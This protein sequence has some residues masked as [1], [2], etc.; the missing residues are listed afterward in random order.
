LQPLNARSAS[1]SISGLG[2]ILC[3]CASLMPGK[4]KPAQ[5]MGDSWALLASLVGFL[6]LLSIPRT[7]FL[8]PGQTSV[9]T[10]ALLFQSTA[11]ATTV[12][13][14]TKQLQILLVIES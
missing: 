10:V 8:S 4:E 11:I 14:S 9:L 5:L 7:K 1:S 2:L 3:L 12:F 6:N 13:S